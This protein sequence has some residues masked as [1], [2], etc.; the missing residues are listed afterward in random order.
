MNSILQ[1][2]ARGSSFF[3]FFNDTATTEIYTL[4]LHD[5]LPIFLDAKRVT[6]RLAAREL[7]LGRHRDVEILC[8]EETRAVG[9]ELALALPLQERELERKN[10][11]GGEEGQV[12]ETEVEQ[13]V[14]DG[15]V[16]RMSAHDV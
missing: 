12:A 10:C 1:S 7:H 2:Y 5:A 4:S 11:R 9:G 14:R 13:D 15:A 6:V 8:D 16:R 3:F